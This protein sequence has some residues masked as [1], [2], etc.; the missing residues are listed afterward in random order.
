MKKL[1]L[2][3]IILSLIIT[4]VLVLILLLP[5][6]KYFK[7]NTNLFAQ[8]DK[9]VLMRDV[10]SPRIIFIGGS[11]ISFSLNSQM[12]KDSL[13]L[14]PINTGIHAS[15]GLKYML[16]N[17]LHYIKEGDIVVISPEYHHFYNN[18]ADGNIELLSVLVDV[19]HNVEDVDL[20]QMLTLSKF[21]PE[22]AASKL[23]IWQ[24]FY[25]ADTVTLN[26]VGRNSFN[27]YGDACVH[28][29]LPRPNSYFSYDVGHTLNSEMFDVLNDYR[30]TLAEKKALL[31][32]TFP[33]FEEKC[34]MKNIVQIKI[35]E[36]QLKD[37]GYNVIG[38]PERYKV[39]DSLIFRTAY[40][41]TKTGVD[42]RTALLIEDLKGVIRVNN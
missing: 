39:N 12:I 13:K 1:F 11:N 26:E 17:S 35:I 33:A 38:S 2:K 7:N 19:T 6:T 36:K 34:C 18:S 24:Y 30:R 28:W 23:K 27:K 8:T 21:V 20:K 22:Y 40:H 15:L 5:P 37:R 9:N 14:N 29:K 10:P 31:Y 25:P 16:R 4:A 42:R 3:L 32:I 41:L